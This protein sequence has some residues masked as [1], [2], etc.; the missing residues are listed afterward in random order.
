MVHV[1]AIH[2][3]SIRLNAYL[4]VWNSFILT[5]VCI[6]TVTGI[7]QGYCWFVSRPLQQSG[8]CSKAS[9]KNFF[10]QFPSA[11]KN[12]YVHYTVVYLCLKKHY[13]RSL[14]KDL[15]AKLLKKI[16]NH[17]LT[18]QNCHKPLICLKKKKQHLWSVIKENTTKWGLPGFS[19]WTKKALRETRHTGT[20]QALTPPTWF[21]SW[22]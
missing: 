3:N 21:Y 18:T 15:I 20:N 22:V 6:D 17:H 19:S 14:K 4:P 5:E 2:Q 13:I 11:Y 10:F 9:H 1:W 7:P 8:Y 16:D 12:V